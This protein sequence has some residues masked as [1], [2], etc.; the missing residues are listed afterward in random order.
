M[1]VQIMVQARMGSTRLPGKVLKPIM[2][3]PMLHYQLERLKRV[4]EAESV[5]VLTTTEKSDDVIVEYCEQNGVDVFRGSSEDVL[6]RYHA[7]AL[8]YSPD[9]IVRSTADCPLIDPALIDKVIQFFKN[10][11]P[12]YDYMST[13]LVR[14][15]PRGMDVEI[16][17]F[18]ALCKAFEQAKDASEREHVTLYLY[19]H[20]EL[21]R[22]QNIAFP[23]DL[24][25]YRL[26]VD[27]SEDFAL[28]KLIFEN[29]YSKLPQFTLEDIVRLLQQ[30]PEWAK[31]NAHIM[32][33]PT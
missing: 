13:A 8:K 5:K 21:F 15:F 22:L 16:F 1:R 3:K 31:I 2:G 7:A 9:T 17:S 11:K 28:I 29:L 18:E 6:D 26:T 10:E 14:T 27:T 20:P 4:K 19:R 23:M 30:H 25:Q 12:P 32:Q 33:K 24:S